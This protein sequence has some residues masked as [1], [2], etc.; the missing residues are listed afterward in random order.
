[1]GPTAQFHLPVAELVVKMLPF[2]AGLFLFAFLR[3]A[4][5]KALYRVELGRLS[6]AGIGDIDRMPGQVFEKYLEAVFKGKGY[7]V[8]RTHYRGDFG[9]DLVVSSGGALT[10]V[11]TKRWKRRVGVK[12]V[13]E[14][15]AARGYYG[16]D[17]AMVI[18]NSY[19]T[20]QAREL[21]GKNHIE[22]WD[23]RRLLDE[24]LKRCHSEGTEADVSIA[25]SAA[26]CLKCGRRLTTKEIDFCVRHASRFDG[27]TYCYRCQRAVAVPTG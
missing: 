9:G 20:G 11:Q 10:V 19:F 13:Q 17:R 16:C 3:L 1:M 7:S 5:K 24:L 26:K 15:A 27:K 23:R 22:L 21:A 25:A 8:T 12:A 2:V 18:T 6:R 14:A 4:L